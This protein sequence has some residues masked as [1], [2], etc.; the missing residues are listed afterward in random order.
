[1]A[2]GLLARA[3]RLSELSDLARTDVHARRRLNRSLRERGME[4]MLRDRAED[5]D[6][7]VLYCLVRL[8]CETSRTE[9]ARQAL[10]TWSRHGLWDSDRD[11]MPKW[12]ALMNGRAALNYQL[13]AAV[14]LFG[15]AIGLAW[16]H[17]ELDS[18]HAVRRVLHPG[19]RRRRRAAP[20]P[21]RSRSGVG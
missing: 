13:V 4:A 11:L 10:N 12:V 9:Q 1:M 17:A 14:F 7:G 5:G 6:R 19:S 18:V 16:S 20:G 2:H 3:E 21:R 8:L 15:L